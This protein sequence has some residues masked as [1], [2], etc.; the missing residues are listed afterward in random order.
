MRIARHNSNSARLRSLQEPLDLGNR[1]LFAPLSRRRCRLCEFRC[2]LRCWAHDTFL[3]ADSR[4]AFRTNGE[5]Q[6]T[7]TDRNPRCVQSAWPNRMQR[8][9]SVAS[10]L[11]SRVAAHQNIDRCPFS[12]II[13]CASDILKEPFQEACLA[14]EVEP[15]SAICGGPGFDGRRITR[16]LR[17]ANRSRNPFRPRVQSARRRRRQIRWANALPNHRRRLRVAIFPKEARI[18]RRASFCSSP[19]H[20]LPRA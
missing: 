3:P 9:S 16:R 5:G 20:W 10:S 11:T 12:D 7:A 4:M 15:A 2:G 19:S 1:R 17:R 18:R 8:S 13:S 6:L 14:G